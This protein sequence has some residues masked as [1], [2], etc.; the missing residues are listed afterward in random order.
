MKS[1]KSSGGVLARYKQGE[2]SLVL[3]YTGFE[4]YE[5]ADKYVKMLHA[6]LTQFRDEAARTLPDK[7]WGNTRGIS[8]L[9]R[10]SLVWYFMD[11]EYEI[12]VTF[13]RLPAIQKIVL[14]FLVPELKKRLPAEYLLHTS[15]ET[16]NP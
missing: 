11:G 2:D 10:P 13:S 16:R 14:E 7:L 4:S 8:E 5:E 15:T 6:L 3:E 1:E 12:R 9:G